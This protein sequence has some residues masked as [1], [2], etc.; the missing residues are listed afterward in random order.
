MPPDLTLQSLRATGAAL[1]DAAAAAILPHFRTGLGADNKAATGFDPVTV[2]DRASEQAM[3]DILAARRPG[4]GICGEEFPPVDSRSG[5]TWVLDPI[6]GTRAF[7]CG[8]PIWGVLIA[9]TDADARPLYGL[10]AQP[11]TGERFEGWTLPGARAAEARSARGSVPM[12]VR[13][14]T[15]LAGATL[16][17]TFPEI[18]TDDERAAFGRVARCVRLVRYGMDCYAYALLAHG[19]IDLVIEAG[20]QRYDVAAPIAVIE[21]AGGIVT[22]WQGG[23]ADLGGR[24]IAAATPELHAEALALL[25]P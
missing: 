9:L 4:D 25:N 10:I 18:G 1:A 21:A 12:A 14:G 6:D 11:W 23:R 13:R 17:T 7:I 16:M 24:V 20:L 2:A 8:A 22:D 19:Q 3:R 15:A 5:L